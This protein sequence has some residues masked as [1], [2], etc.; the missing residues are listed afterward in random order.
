[1]LAVPRD[2][3]TMNDAE[4]P[5][6]NA[7]RDLF[8]EA[9][10]G[11]AVDF[12]QLRL[13]L[14][15]AVD[16]DAGVE[17]YRLTW[18]GRRDAIHL[19][20]Q[21]ADGTLVPAREGSLDFE[22]AVHAVVEGDNLEVLKI[23]QRAYGGRIG[24]IFIDPPYNTGG[25]FLYRDHFRDRTESYL[26]K[27]G[28][29]DGAGR[30]T[31]RP[32]TGG[33]L[34]SSWLSMMYPRLLAARS[35][36]RPEGFLVVTIDDTEVH[37]L[38]HLLDEIFG[39]ENFIANVVWHKAYVANMTAKHV[40][41]THDHILVYARDARRAQ[42]GRIP[43]TERQVAAFTNPDDDP[44]GPWK[45]EN[46][47]SGKPYAAG[48]FAIITPSGR[49]VLPPK[50]RA[51]RCHRQQF[52]AWRSDGRIWFGQAG[53]GRP[54]LKKFLTEVREGLTPETWWSHQEVGSNKEA[55]SQLKAL[56]DGEAVFDTPKPVRLLRRIVDLFSRPEDVVLDFFAGAGATGEAVLQANREDG[57]RRRF[58][59]VQ[60][61]EPIP[62]PHGTIAEVCRERIRRVL[63]R[64]EHDTGLRCF[65]LAH[66][67][68]ST[69]RAP[70]PGAD[71]ATQ[72]LGAIQ[73]RVKDRAPDDLIW[74]V[75]LRSGVGLDAAVEKRE[76]AGQALYV[77]QDR[78][79]ACFEAPLRDRTLEAI[80]E[81]SPR[82]LVLAEGAF[83]GDESTRQNALFNFRGAGTE[84]RIL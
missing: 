40:S 16:S 4:S 18:S 48:Q 36:L 14:G 59:L 81:L 62:G 70:S 74:E 46:L 2:A 63:R 21:P 32:E 84:V 9:F 67:G 22:E 33:R 78:L 43:R 51:W 20:A 66:S 71:V 58:V 37:N 44:R 39:A 76:V 7:L 5:R 61:P 49:E 75:M 77:V 80:R 34:H 24:L 35:L 55:S 82:R 79:V 6:L 12:E 31:S 19:G 54:M 57:G 60:L 38:R 73:R 1:M 13:A 26:R 83:E 65:R 42:V 15:D 27:T 23:L 11:D 17:R 53:N 50:G 45:A 68:W 64:E 41:A 72:L 30:L 8:P 47:S 28:Q 29:A 69:W 56:F 3:K 10:V 25:Q 52:E